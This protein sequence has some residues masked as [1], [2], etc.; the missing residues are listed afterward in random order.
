MVQGARETRMTGDEST[1]QIELLVLD[2]AVEDQVETDVAGGSAF[3]LTS[4]DPEKETENADTVAIIPYGLCTRRSRRRGRPTRR[5][6][7]IADGCD[8][9][10][11]V[12][13]VGHEPDPAAHGYP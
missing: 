6:T 10:R 12:A 13:A 4:R 1:G 3:A 2:G 7:R 9:A 11:R 8:D 5:Q